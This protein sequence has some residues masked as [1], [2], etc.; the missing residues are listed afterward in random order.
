MNGIVGQRRFLE[1]VNGLSEH[2][3]ETES[4]EITRLLHKTIKK[5]TE[6]IERY[7]FNTAISALMIFLNTAEKKG[8]NSETYTTFLALLA[9]FAPHLAEELWSNHG[10]TVS[11]HLSEWPVANPELFGDERVTLSVQINGK[12]RGTIEVLSKET[13]EN[14]MAQIRKDTKLAS[15][16]PPKISKVI[17]VQGRII[18][19]VGNDS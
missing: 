6:D 7:K 8:L 18:N 12:M 9:P 15:K 1:R 10:N 13:E 14:V 19:V 17:Y 4:V 5:V 2:I 11:I 3:S 16:L